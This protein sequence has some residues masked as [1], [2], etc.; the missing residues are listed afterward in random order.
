MNR[1]LYRLMYWIGQSQWDTDVTP[2]EVA[3]AFQA[4]GNLPGPVLD[5]GCGSGTNVIFMAK[6][7]RQA[8]GIDFVPQAVAAAREKAQRM[9]LSERTHFH[10]GDVTQLA[11]LGLPRCSFALDM[12]CFHGLSTEGQRRYAKELAAILIPGGRYLLYTL[13]PRKQMGIAFGVL[14][15]YV[16]AV[17]APGFDI[18]R[19]ERGTFWGSASTW[20]WMERKP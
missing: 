16:E 15:A 14:P 4:E 13:H 17:F 18:V 12:G 11:E 1:F 20:F 10:L 19:V 8:I 5:L 9:G 2:P 6:Q 7:G 3:E